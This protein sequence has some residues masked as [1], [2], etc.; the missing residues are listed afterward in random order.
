MAG[1][2]AALHRLQPVAFLQALGDEASA[3]AAPVA[4]SH[5]GSGGCVP[6]GPCR[7][8]ACR[9]ARPADRTV[10]L[11]FLAEAA[12]GR[13]GGHVHA[14]AGHVVFPAVI[15]AAQAGFLVA[16]EPQRDAAVGAEFIDQAIR[17]PL[18]RKASSRSERSFTRTG[19]QSF[20]G[21]SSQQR[22]N[23]VAAEQLA[24][25]RARAGLG[26]QIVL[27]FPEHRKISSRH[28][29]GVRPTPSA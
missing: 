29:R 11:I 12:L 2:D 25:R 3:P 4:N 20:S 24:H 21:N 18:S 16:P 7:S 15:G 22:R 13:L 19:G 10:S 27:F 8:T 14:L 28:G 17:P 23:P 26:Q 6:A 5:S 1:I 9:R